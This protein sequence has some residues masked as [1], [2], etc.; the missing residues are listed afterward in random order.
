ML[1]GRLGRA[2]ETAG[3]LRAEV[4]DQTLPLTTAID[5]PLRRQAVAAAT[6][7]ATPATLTGTARISRRHVRVGRREV[8]TRMLPRITPVVVAAA[9]LMRHLLALI[10]QRRVVVILHRH[11]HI[12]RRP[13]P[14]H[15]APTPLL[16]AVMAAEVGMAADRMEV[17]VEAPRVEAGVAAVLPTEAAVPH[18][19][20]VGRTA[21][22]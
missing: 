21:T 16:A 8:I 2:L 17:A 19:A 6:R 18:E 15:H 10:Q 5:R 20:V 11:G 12:R 4:H 7:M 13:R 9:A 1:T 22:N 3:L 14:H